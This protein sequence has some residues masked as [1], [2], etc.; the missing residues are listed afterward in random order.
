MEK[1]WYSIVFQNLSERIETRQEEAGPE[2][3]LDVLQSEL[4]EIDELRQLSLLISEPD[5][6]DYTTT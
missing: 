4:E 2:Y 5:S 1:S 3:N 6:V